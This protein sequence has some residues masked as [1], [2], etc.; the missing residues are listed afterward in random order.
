MELLGLSITTSNI[1]AHLTAQ[2]GDGKV[3]GN[4]L[5]NLANLADPGGP[6]E[7]PVAAR[8]TRLR[9][10]QY[11]YHDRRFG[12]AHRPRT[13]E[14]LTVTV[15]PIDLNLLGLE[16]QTDPIT[17]TV[18]TQGGDG[19]LLG[20]L[21]TGITS[22]LNTQ[23]VSN[24]LNNVL[25]T[26]VDLVNSVSLTVNGV[27]SGSFDTAAASVIPVLDLFVAPVHL[28]LLGAVVDTSPIHL[29]VTAH[30]GDGL[31]LG[32]VIAELANLF[33]PPLPDQL[34]IDFLNSRLADLLARLDEQIPDIAPA[35]V[36]PVSL[37][38]DQFLGLTVPPLDLNLLGLVLQTSPIT[39][40]AFANPGDGQLLG[41]ILTTALNTLGA[42][43]RT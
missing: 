10:P 31:V 8:S 11:G 2:T 12:H 23:N 42:T 16:V 41:N 22:L 38:T 20:N 39:V 5:Y 43:P 15:K 35:P 6:S 7:P 40:N 32:N 36:P 25:S 17:V 19:K 14:L 3:L 28:D 34:D 37:D 24:A 1:E 13:E 9:Q 26:T 30:S 29:T 33:N 21:L 18:S 4:L 27:G